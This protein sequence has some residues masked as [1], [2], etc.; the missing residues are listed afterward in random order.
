MGTIE[1]FKQ[2]MNDEIACAQAEVERFTARG[3]GLTAAA[4]IKHDGLVEGLEQKVDETKARLRALGKT[5][6]QDWDDLR[7]GVMSSWGA[8]QS[9]L[10]DAIVSFQDGP[11]VT[12]LHGNESVLRDDIERF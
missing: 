2:K 9:A 4:K 3:M 8:L 10:K 12:G 1:A 11:P 6:D 5:E 7:D